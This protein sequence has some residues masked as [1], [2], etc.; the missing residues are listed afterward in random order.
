[1][2]TC[3]PLRLGRVLPR[4]MPILI[5]ADSPVLVRRTCAAWFLRQG[6]PAECEAARRPHSPVRCLVEPGEGR[7]NHGKGGIMTTTPSGL[8]GG[9][10]DPGLDAI[11]GERRQLINLTYRLLGSL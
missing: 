7:R 2:A 10:P 8:G 5:K 4:M 9:R 3:S 6:A 1:M 11:M